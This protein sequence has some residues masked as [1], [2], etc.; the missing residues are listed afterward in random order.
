M[1]FIKKISTTGGCT[2]LSEFEANLIYS[3]RTVRTTRR[4]PVQTNKQGNKQTNKGN[5]YQGCFQTKGIVF[6]GPWAAELLQETM[7]VSWRVWSGRSGSS[8]IHPLAFS[9]M[10]SAIQRAD[11]GVGKKGKE[12]RNGRVNPLAGQVRRKQTCQLICKLPVQQSRQY[13]GFFSP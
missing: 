3:S 8:F 13:H 9:P 7:S 4:N 11:T 5:F 6:T 1:L 12:E 10:N 2:R